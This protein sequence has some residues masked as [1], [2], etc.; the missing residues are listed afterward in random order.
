MG[1]GTCRR[2]GA[3]QERPVCA[4]LVGAKRLET[5]IV[6]NYQRKPLFLRSIADYLAGMTDSYALAEYDTMVSAYPRRP[7]GSP[8]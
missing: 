7:A 8:D 6:A 5:E 2:R 3:E 4:A 1:R